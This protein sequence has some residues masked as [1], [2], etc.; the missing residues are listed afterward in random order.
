MKTTTLNNSKNNGRSVNDISNFNIIESI[1]KGVFL[2]GDDEEI[3][4]GGWR[5]YLFIGD[6]RTQDAQATFSFGFA[7]IGEH[8]EID[9]LDMPSY[10]NNENDLQNTNC[11]PSERGGYKIA[12]SNENV[13]KGLNAAQRQAEQW[14]E[15]TWQQMNEGIVFEGE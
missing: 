14:A 1:P 7:R 5:T 15:L 9:I 10:G 3:P 6:Y 13:P 4:P 12:L 2:G 8:V 11:I